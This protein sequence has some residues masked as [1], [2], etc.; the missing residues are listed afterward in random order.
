MFPQEIIDLIEDFSETNINVEYNLRDG[1]DDSSLV[2][3]YIIMTTFSQRLM[4]Y[5]LDAYNEIQHKYFSDIETICDSMKISLK[6][7]YIQPLQIRTFQRQFYQFAI[8]CQKIKGQFVSNIINKLK[9]HFAIQVVSD[10]EDEYSSK[11]QKS[12]SLTISIRSIIA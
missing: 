8:T 7:K 12:G 6:Y 4:K 2:A 3:S 10:R 9:D 5:V 11:V 1:L